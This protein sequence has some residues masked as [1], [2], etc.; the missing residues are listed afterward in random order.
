[1]WLEYDSDKN[2]ML[3]TYECEYFI[4]ELVLHMSSDRASNYNPSQFLELFNKFDEDKN[5]FIEKS[6]MGVFIKQVFK[7]PKK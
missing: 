3:D 2:G 7:N 6:E 4:N 5:G 1:M